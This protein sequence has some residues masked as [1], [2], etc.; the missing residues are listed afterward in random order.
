MSNALAK[1]RLR[2]RFARWDVDGNGL[3]ELEDFRQEAARI[4]AG[5]GASPESA[6]AQALHDA[7]E[8]LYTHLAVQAGGSAKSGISEQGFLQA[9]EQMLFAEGEAAFNRALAPMVKALVALSDSDGDGTLSSS[10]F[11]AWLTGIGLPRTHAAE[12]FRKI[13]ENG[14]GQLSEDELL[15]A[16]REYHYGRLDVELLG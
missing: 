4:T 6:G 16:V 14:D 8:A 11:E 9:T 10:E 13:D 1:D 2:K 5:F 7:F 12:T 3:L 15:R